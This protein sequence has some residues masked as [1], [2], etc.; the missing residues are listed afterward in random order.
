MATSGRHLARRSAV[1]AL[2]QWDI[3]GQDAARI[4]RDFIDDV[5]LKGR[6]REYFEKIVKQVPENISQID[7]LL[8]AHMDR[9]VASLDSLEKSVLRVGTYEVLFEP[10]VPRNVVINEAIEI[11]K[12]FC[13]DNGY[14]FV[15]GVLDKVIKTQQASAA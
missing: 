5:R 2:Y 7:T 13:S 11:A 14:R 10:D 3:T 15:N 9:T 1:Q 8:Q 12:L 6:H 4:Q